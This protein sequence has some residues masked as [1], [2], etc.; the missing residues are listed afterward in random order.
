MVQGQSK[1]H[2]EVEHARTINENERFLI[3]K[4]FLESHDESR[5]EIIV[6][7]IDPSKSYIV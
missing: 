5:E 6:E 1:L 4:R 7:H 3:K 2:S